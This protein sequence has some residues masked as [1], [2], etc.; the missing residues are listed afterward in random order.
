MTVSE[1]FGVEG[2]R[3]ARAG[4]GRRCTRRVACRHRHPQLDHHLDGVA[5]APMERRLREPSGARPRQRNDGAG[6]PSWPPWGGLPPLSHPYSAVS[7]HPDDLDRFIDLR[8]RRTTGAASSGDRGCS[9][10]FAIP[11][12]VAKSATFSGSCATSPR[13]SGIWPGVVSG[14]LPRALSGRRIPVGGSGR[15]VLRVQPPP[16]ETAASGLRHL[17]PRTRRSPDL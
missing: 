11:T 4:E 3:D 7:E 13:P 16:D 2:V 1:L 5:R 15:A 6:I 8:R 17:V 9:P 12:R 10:H 14:L